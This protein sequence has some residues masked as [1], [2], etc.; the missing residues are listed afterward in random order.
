MLIGAVVADA[1]ASCLDLNWT[2]QGYSGDEEETFII[3]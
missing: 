3:A 2:R 1:N